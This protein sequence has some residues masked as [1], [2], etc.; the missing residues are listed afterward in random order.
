MKVTTTF[1]SE[2]IHEFHELFFINNKDNKII[3]KTDLKDKFATYVFFKEIAKF[4]V[5]KGVRAEYINE[6]SKNCFQFAVMENEEIQPIKWF[7]LW[8]NEKNSIFHDIAFNTTLIKKN[9]FLVPLGK[10]PMFYDENKVFSRYRE[11]KIKRNAYKYIANQ[12][13]KNE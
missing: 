5:S 11:L 7:D 13:K 2:K 1:W 12:V 10:F 3:F 6:E 9:G 4:V 8:L